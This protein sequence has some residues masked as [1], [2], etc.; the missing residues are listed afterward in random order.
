ML[1]E[2]LPEAAPGL[3]GGSDSAPLSTGSADAAQESEESS[4]EEDGGDAAAEGQE[5]FFRPE[6]HEWGPLTIE[7]VYTGEVF[8]KAHGGLTPDAATRYRGNLDLT[9]LLD[10]E[11]ANLWAGGEIF[12]YFHQAHGTTLTPDFIGDGQYYS[13]IDTGPRPQTLSRLGEYWYRHTSLDEALALKFGRQDA[14]ADF[15]YCELGGDFL[16]SSFVTLPNLPM[17]FWPFQSLGASGLYQ[18]N[19]RWRVGSGVYDHSHNQAQWWSNP[20]D[21]G[22]FMIWQADWSPFADLPDAPLTVLKFGSWHSTADTLS[23]D[24]VDT[25]DGNYGFYTTL[26]R[27]LLPELGAAD[28]GLGGFFQFS[29]APGDRNQVDRAYA[30]GLVYRGLLVGRDADTCGIAYTGIRFSNQLQVFTGQTSEDVFEVFYKARL[31][32]G[33]SWQPDL[34]YIA[35]PNGLE[36]DALV[37]GVRFE[38]SF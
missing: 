9:F 17:P 23:I 33:I 3:P 36:R 34:Q 35:R 14:N 10:M 37:A 20:S 19:E 2:G 18:V 26:D 24:E 27:M 6:F 5:T 7:S 30:A 8:S 38:C 12:V 25:F 4:E 1:Q 22:L 31:R 21:Q 28:Q 32:R 11:Q 13:N 15:A 16:N 29:W